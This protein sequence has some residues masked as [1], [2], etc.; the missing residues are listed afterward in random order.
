MSYS[1]VSEHRDVVQYPLKG[2]QFSGY[3]AQ[4]GLFP[5]D[6]N[7]QLEVNL[8]YAVHHPMGENFFLSNYSSVF[9]ST[10]KNQPYTLYDALG[11]RNLIVRGFENYV[12]EGPA[13]ALN[14]ST[15]KKKIF[16]NAWTIDRMPFE[17]FSYLPLAIYLK[18]F[19]D[20]GYVENYPYYNEKNINQIYPN[21]LL[22]GYGMGLDFVTAYDVVFRVEYTVTQDGKGAFFLNLKKEF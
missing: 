12:V 14:K 7:Q 1:F 13:F 6:D 2:Y 15:L 9:W 8:S 10:P 22:S 16:S 5:E 19:V 20:F 18:A 21:R 3:V 17:Q 4:T 11:Y